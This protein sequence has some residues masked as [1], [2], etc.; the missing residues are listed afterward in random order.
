MYF[1]IL[2]LMDM[3][4]FRPYVVPYLIPVLC[5]HT[6]FSFP[7]LLPLSLLWIQFL[8]C[9]I[10][11]QPHFQH[12]PWFRVFPYAGYICVFHTMITSR[13]FANRYPCRDFEKNASM[14]SVL[15][16]AIYMVLISNRSLE[17]KKCISICLEFLVH[18][19]F[20][21]FSSLLHSDYPGTR[22]SA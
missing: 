7:Y 14:W 15:Q 4:W 5:P 22:C 21:F 10:Q 13:N 6:R 17:K 19:F 18:D 20:Q 16:N 12:A 2:L 3:A 8:L 11:Y 9:L 1:V